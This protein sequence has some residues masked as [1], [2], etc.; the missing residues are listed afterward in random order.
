M[1]VGLVV[2]TV[3]CGDGETTTTQEWV[4]AADA[5]C[6]EM[7]AQLDPIPEPQTIKEFADASAQVNQIWRNGIDELRELDLPEGNE[8]A[9]TEA[10]DAFDQLADASLQWSDAF[11]AS[12]SMEVEDM[13]PELE[14][15]FVELET[16]STQA[17]Q[18]AE[19]TG[20]QQCFTNQES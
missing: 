7:N 15:L 17:T 14:M 1:T 11:T 3:G 6:A 13:T 5:I 18:L 20:L 19:R 2:L 16:S 9:I 12:G 10:L 8:A 4:T